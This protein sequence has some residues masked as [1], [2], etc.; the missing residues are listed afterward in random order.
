MVNTAVSAPVESEFVKRLRLQQEEFKRHQEQ[1]DTQARAF[2]TEMDT[3]T[4]TLFAS[5][6]GLEQAQ[7]SKSTQMNAL[8]KTLGD[9]Q[10]GLTQQQHQFPV[11]L[12]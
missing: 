10:S 1:A 9:L 2:Q 12:K 8:Q 3:R 4:Q 6:S 11:N 5:I 7:K